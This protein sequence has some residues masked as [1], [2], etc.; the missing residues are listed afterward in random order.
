MII[1]VQRCS[2]AQVSVSNK[3][4]GK[5]NFGLVVFLGV[6]QDDTKDDANFLINKI[7]KMR[8]FNDKNNKMNLSINDVKGSLLVVSQ[9]T[10]CGNIKKGHRPSFINA[11]SPDNANKLYLYF[12][13]ELEKI[14]LNVESGEFGA[15]MD[16]EFINDGPVTFVLNS[17]D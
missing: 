10:L 13:Y 12:I 9:F 15:M 7:S 5:I 6:F 2:K 3:I 1:V 8:I 11:A 14:G 17:R 16:V 4:L